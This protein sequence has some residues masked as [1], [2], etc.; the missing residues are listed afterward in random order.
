[1]RFVIVGASAAGISAAE[2]LRCHDECADI[3]I[4]SD[5]E[6][7]YSRPMLSYYLA[8][9]RDEE[10]L[11]YRSRD[12]FKDN[13]IEAIIARAVKLDPEK[14][15]VQLEDGRKVDY[16]RLLLATGA[17]PRFPKVEGMDKEGVFGL[18]KIT[19]VEGMLARL[20]HATRAVVLGA[21]LVG[22]KAAAGLKQHGLDVT[23]LVGSLQ[24]LSQM[25]DESSSEVFKQIFEEN[26]VPVITGVQAAEVL[27][28]AQV[29]GL[30]LTSGEVYPCELVVVGKGVDPNLDL[31]EGTSIK[32]DYGILIDE[33]C[34]TNVPDIYAAGDAAQAMDVLRGEPWINALWPCAVEQGRIA[35]L[36]M[37]GEETAY[38]GSMRMNSVQFFDLSVISAGLAVLTPGPLGSRQG[39][40]DETL[41]DRPEPHVYRKVFLKDDTIVGFVLIG[42]IET[43][44]VLR[45]LMEK[46]VDVSDMKDELLSPRLDVG[47]VLPLIAESHEGVIETEFQELL[48]TVSVGG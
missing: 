28:K 9:T 17:S 18:R 6:L 8:G 1:M 13:R 35:A 47:R 7:I 16:D 36:N 23:V 41:E 20:P 31:V 42:E 43:A 27:G 15:Q 3:V 4:I 32:M 2:T 22:L 39:E 11:L 37:A 5:E 19:D 10:G 44:G 14:N 21:G 29:E 26:G 38:K 40:H 25:L 12:F 24:V 33:H 30:K 45:T 34:R 48:E 46:R